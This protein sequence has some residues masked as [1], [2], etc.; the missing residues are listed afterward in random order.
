[1]ELNQLNN[2]HDFSIPQRQSFAAIFL[3]MLKSAV[4]I[5]K[6]LWPI[7]LVTLLKPGKEGQANK[8]LFIMIGFASLSI[9][10]ALVRFLFYRFHIN[11]DNLVINTGWLKKKTLSIPLQSIQAVHLEQNLWQQVFGV[12][13]VSFDSVGSEKIE[14]QIDAI[15]TSKAEL[16]KQMLLTQDKLTLL[17]KQEDDQSKIYR[18]SG[19]DLLKLSLSANHIEAFLI[20]FAVSIN[21]L[22]D[23]REAFDFDGWG[24]IGTFAD[25]MQDHMILAITALILFVALLSVA[26]SIVRSVIK[27][28]GFNLQTNNEKWNIS[29]GLIN[30][31]QKIIPHRKIQLYSWHTNWLRRKLNFWMVDIKTIGQEETKEK[32]RLK[33]PLT[34][35][36]AAI[37]LAFAYQ[38]S[39]VLIPG[40][41]RMIE[42][43]YWYRKTLFPALPVTLLLTGI[44]FIW[45]QWYALWIMLLLVYAAV[46][47][48]CWYKKFRWHANEEGIQLYSGLWGRR[49]QLLVWK[50]IQQVNFT[51]SPYQR[52][53]QLASI[54]FTTAGGSVTLPY[55]TLTNAHSLMNTV[56]YLVE[57]KNEKWM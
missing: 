8:W 9:L 2:E 54:H 6:S 29:F 13:K 25:G 17:E 26:F 21:L 43:A 35:M 50:K 3:L 37:D 4:T 31:K 39:P 27:Y 28:Y 40:A 47:N 45:L 14:A 42:P 10:L 11:G 7:L 32:H 30:R 53:Q 15:K 18:L 12:S 49:Y 55:I 5:G 38:S 34:S 48:Y 56:L 57:S 16:L 44:G 33:I 24:L 23:L 36:Q 1:M 52:S 51:Q 22:D 46:R 19:S 20:L 41:G